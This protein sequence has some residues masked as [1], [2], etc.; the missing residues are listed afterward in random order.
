[1]LSVRTSLLLLPLVVAVS[2]ADKKTDK[3]TDP[4]PDQQSQGKS[5]REMANCNPGNGK[6]K[7]FLARSDEEIWV[8]FV[9]EE[10]SRDFYFK[11]RAFENHQE[12]ADNA[13]AF[14]R[15][16]RK[17]GQWLQIDFDALRQLEKQDVVSKEEFSRTIKF[18]NFYTPPILSR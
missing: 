17:T 8:R 6:D 14:F 18:V 4:T 7:A 5:E 12:W 9:C 11:V 15:K 2:C 16:A 1:M 3:V 10:V 13:S